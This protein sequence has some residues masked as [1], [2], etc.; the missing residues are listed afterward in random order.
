[1][2]LL[3]AGLANERD[4]R[5]DQ[6]GYKDK[7]IDTISK[8]QLH[9]VLQVSSRPCVSI[10]MPTRRSGVQPGASSPWIE[11]LTPSSGTRLSFRADAH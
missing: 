1:M 10:F 8:S 4:I 11:L 5:T 3:E 2:E 7:M 6:S 9:E